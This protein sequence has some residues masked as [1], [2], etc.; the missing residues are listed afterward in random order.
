MMD[1]W[2][3]EKERETV[4]KQVEKPNLSLSVVIHDKMTRCFWNYMR[5]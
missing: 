2:M 3:D 1:G 5:V 4:R